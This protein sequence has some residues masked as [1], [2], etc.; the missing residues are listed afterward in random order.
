VIELGEDER[1]AWLYPLH[2]ELAA[3]APRPAGRRAIT[4]EAGY[5]ACFDYLTKMLPLPAGR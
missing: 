1:L 3:S 5:V 4:L 2:L